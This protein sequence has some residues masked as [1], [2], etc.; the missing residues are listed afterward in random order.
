MG[1]L[2]NGPG[3]QAIVAVLGGYFG[4]NK[5]QYYNAADFTGWPKQSGGGTWGYV[6]SKGIVTGDSNYDANWKTWLIHLDLQ[7]VNQK[8]NN[9][10]TAKTIGDAIADA[11]TNYQTYKQIEFFVVPDDTNTSHISAEAVDFTDSSGVTTKCITVYT[12]VYNNVKDVVVRERK[13]R[14]KRR[15]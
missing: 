15:K 2:F 1:M 11:I 8:K 12:P 13:T 5:L 9:E 7:Q 14:P 6:S 4:P 3:T 10:K